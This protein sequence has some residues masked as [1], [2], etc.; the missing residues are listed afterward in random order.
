MNFS[1]MWNKGV[2]VVHVDV[3][4]RGMNLA[5]SPLRIIL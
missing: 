3:E 2:M 1:T 4:L 5:K